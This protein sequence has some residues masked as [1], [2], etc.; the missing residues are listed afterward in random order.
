[1]MEIFESESFTIHCLQCGWEGSEDDL[2]S[3]SEGKPCCPECGSA[4]LEY[5]V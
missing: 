2:E 4:E 1:M 3:D 5:D